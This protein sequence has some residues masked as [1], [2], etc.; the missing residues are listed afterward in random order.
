MAKVNAKGSLSYGPV[1]AT[2]SGETYSM[3]IDYI[4]YLTVSMPVRV[5]EARTPAVPP[6]INGEEVGWEV[7]RNRMI[8]V[9]EGT[10]IQSKLRYLAIEAT[11]FTDRDYET[12]SYRTPEVVK[13]AA[14]RETPPSHRVRAVTA[15]AAKNEEVKEI[16]AGSM[17]IYV[18]V[19]IRVRADFK[20]AGGEIK[21]G[22]PG[23]SAEASAGRISGTLSVQTLG[24]GGEQITSLM[25]IPSD[26]SPA[27]IQAAIQ[28]AASIKVKM[29]DAST[30]IQPM[31]VGFES[32][33]TEG[34]VVA[35]LASFVYSRRV[36]V[37]P[38]MSAKAN[39]DASHHLW[40][41]W[42]DPHDATESDKPG[43]ATSDRTPEAPRPTAPR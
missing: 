13:E 3:V 10:G 35:E 36:E 8:R 33:V 29:Y 19:G 43:E 34:D 5:F 25:P 40:F 31:I 21:G 1:T 39:P 28:A 15:R 37:T 24:I 12:V 26:L 38:Q 22:L 4:K 14:A 2:V 42:R 9:D 11:A 17:P 16:F 27:S 18:G 32:P 41:K 30:I 6:K 7:L 23:L 20:S